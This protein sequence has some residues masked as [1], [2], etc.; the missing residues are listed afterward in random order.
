MT[1]IALIVEMHA[2]CN[3]L[4]EKQNMINDGEGVASQHVIADC[5]LDNNEKFLIFMP[6]AEE[7]KIHVCTCI[8]SGHAC[9]ICQ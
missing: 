1:A 3:F 2:W 8:D 6:T 7:L 4:G 5:W 9:A